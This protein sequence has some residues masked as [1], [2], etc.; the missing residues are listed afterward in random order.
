MILRELNEILKEAEISLE[1]NEDSELILQIW[2][3]I[4]RIFG[5]LRDVNDLLGSITIGQRRRV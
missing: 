4:W 3:K 2:K 5:E 1:N